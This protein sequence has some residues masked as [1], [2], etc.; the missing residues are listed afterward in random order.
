MT[1]DKKN[2]AGH[3]N[4]TLLADIGNIRIDQSASKSEIFEAL[5][6]FRDGQ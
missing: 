3:V 4:F 2:I 1:H 5:D 6:F